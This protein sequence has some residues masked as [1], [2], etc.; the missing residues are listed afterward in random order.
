MSKLQTIGASLLCAATFISPICVADSGAE[1]TGQ[2]LSAYEL[3]EGRR[4]FERETFGGNGR[5]CQTCHSVANGTQTLEQIADLFAADPFGPLFRGDGSDDG[6][7]NGASR[8]LQE[9]TILVT[10]PLPA[11]VRL[12]DDPSARTVTLHRGIPSTIN[13]PALDP[14]L[15]YDGRA[16]NLVE[17][18]RDAIRTHAVATRAP[19]EHE[20]SLI[21]AFQQTKRF[22]SSK[23]L[24]EFA[25]GDEAPSL[26]PG[27]TESEKRGR[28]FFLDVPIS[29]YSKDGL[30]AIC[31]SG[32][33]LNTSNG[34]NPLPPGLGF[35]PKGERFQSILSAELLPGSEPLRTYIITN[36][37]GS[38]TV[39]ETSDPGRALITGDFRG[40]P[41][42]NLAQF[43]ISSLRNVRNT[44]PYFHNNAART[45]EE[46]MAHYAK[47][48]S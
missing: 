41:F 1:T 12:M 19:T 47:F 36:P 13:T 18:A 6:A 15:M 27:N 33:L 32:P 44:A 24:F 22:F 16:P 20:L 43:K 34:F 14:V 28:R 42:G 35:V 3:R 11:N 2:K 31:H 7:G 21:A 40:F 46:V 29:P 38:E 4:L 23:K 37:D 8:I 25:A 39:V 30:C 48:F 9:G 5:T 26:P 10:L 17:Q 45:L